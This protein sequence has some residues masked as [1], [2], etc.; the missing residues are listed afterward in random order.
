MDFRYLRMGEFFSFS[1]FGLDRRLR[2]NV[3]TRRMMIENDEERGERFEIR[4][5]RLLYFARFQGYRCY[6]NTGIIL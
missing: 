1:R 3:I 4:N 2:V 5:S 6:F